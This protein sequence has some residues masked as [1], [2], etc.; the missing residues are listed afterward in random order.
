[1]ENRIF[2]DFVPA[3]HCKMRALTDVLQRFVYRALFRPAFVLVKVSLKLEFGLVGVHKKLLPRTERQPA[4]IA[5]R[6]A[7]GGPDESYDFEISIRHGTIMA[8]H[9][10]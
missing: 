6:Q 9:R 7:W 1:L 2:P 3:A 10:H 5:K 8:R 4:Y